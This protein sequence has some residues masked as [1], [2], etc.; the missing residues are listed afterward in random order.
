MVVTFETPSAFKNS[1]T[2][3]LDANLPKLQH[4]T[5]VKPFFGE[6]MHFLSK[7]S[8][9]KRVNNKTLNFIKSS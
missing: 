6:K 2:K 3:S 7:N 8:V 4:G 5:M 1:M 9:L